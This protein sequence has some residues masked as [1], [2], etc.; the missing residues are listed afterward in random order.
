M[1]VTSM[2]SLGLLTDAQRALVNNLSRIVVCESSEED[3]Y[4]FTGT[5]ESEKESIIELDKS[6]KQITK[7]N[8][9]IDQRL[10]KIF[11]I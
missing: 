9:S 10:L 11:K 8:S 5:D 6:I 1:R 7:S 2:T 4:V 3:E